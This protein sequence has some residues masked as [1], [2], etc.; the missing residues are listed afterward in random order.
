MKAL[1]PIADIHIPEP[2]PDRE[3]AT[4]I[5]DRTF[6]FRNLKHLLGAADYS[7][8]G[9]R[10]AG[11]AAADETQRE[12]AR[13]I[14]SG[15]TLQQLYDQPLTDDA[16]RTDTIMRVNY[17]IDPAA[18]AAIR[19]LTL[20][21]LKDHLLQQPGDVVKP[22]GRALTGPMAAALV[23]L[24]DI[25]ELI[26]LAKKFTRTTRARTCIGQRGTLSSRLQ[27]NH[28]TDHLDGLT[29]L[30]YLGLSMGTGDCLLGVNPAEDTVQNIS[31]ILKQLDTIRRRTGAPTQICVL[32]H[33]KTQMACLEK[34]VPVE[35]LFQS[36]AGT[37]RTLVEE[38]DVT[39]DY[40]DFAWETMNRIGPLRDVAEQMMYFETGQGSEVSYGKHNGMD[41]ATCEALCYGLARRYDPFMVNNVTGFIGPETH[42][43]NMEMILSN[44]QDHCMGKLMG[45]PMG[46]APCYT[47]HSGITC[48][49]QQIATELLTAAG[50]NY[51]MDVYLGAD[52]MLA[53]FDTSSHDDQTLREIH[54]LNPA[55]EYAEW[56]VSKGIFIKSARGE[57]LRGPNWGDPKIFCSSETEFQSLLESVPAAYGFDNAGPRPANHVTRRSRFN[58]AT[59][60]GAIYSDLDA[61]KLK[62]DGM[63]PEHFIWVATMADNR[64]THLNHPEL[65]T[66]LSAESLQ[67]LRTLPPAD[68][69]IVISD[70]LSADAIHHNIPGLLPV[71]MDGLASRDLC[72][73]EIIIAP[74][75]RVKLAE[76]IARAV[77]PRLVI[78]LIGERPGGDAQASKSMSA[79]MAFALGNG[80]PGATDG[81]GSFE[82]T[83]ISNIYHKGIPPL[84]AGS[85]IAEK[86]LAI[87]EHQA[88]GNRLEEMLK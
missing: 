8:A 45:L 58:Q 29:L 53:Y 26:L 71:L 83:V 13:S 70:G 34:G 50:A 25:H 72:P 59:A 75:G 84:E 5:M 32:G 63:A 74:F 44:L 3:Y 27:P 15:L 28:P 87:L 42:R 48:E 12:A 41:M 19:H 52:R 24:L 54:G 1:T 21:G 40:L 86:A 69:R 17:D 76:A 31:A 73:G 20:G 47:L 62:V 85:L 22:I 4:R 39:V 68:V 77:K 49:G 30:T 38:F 81:A 36:L 18:F 7:K 67:R 79:Y 57:Y 46:M 78:M 64:E 14:L 43:D 9:D 66:R 80:Q 37:D 65:G 6:T 82:Y 60:R 35:I 51:Y 55:P 56:A 33:V 23:K 11:L 88:A 10:A 2:G 61:R 16:G